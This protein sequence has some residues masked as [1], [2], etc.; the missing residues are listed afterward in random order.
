MIDQQE[1]NT[2]SEI[3]YLTG[4]VTQ[5]IDNARC[6]GY[7][8][9]QPE[10]QHYHLGPCPF[11]IWRDY[12]EH[13]WFNAIDYTTYFDHKA[14]ATAISIVMGKMPIYAALTT[15]YAFVNN[16]HTLIVFAATKKTQVA[17]VAPL[18][19]PTEEWLMSKVAYQEEPTIHVVT[20][21]HPLFSESPLSGLPWGTMP[22][23][24]M[25]PPELQYTHNKE[26]GH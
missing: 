7:I 9:G 22:T 4:L 25:V 24:D 20:P 3:T 2:Q 26:V 16:K 17:L 12:R 10:T 23:A 15:R 14:S 21:A 13:G 8:P 6:H 11:I 5:Y 1:M 19:P 18:L